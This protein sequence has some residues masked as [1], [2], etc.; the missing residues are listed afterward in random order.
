M[1]D[2]KTTEKAP[3]AEAPVPDLL[4]DALRRLVKLI[5]AVRY[6]PPGHPAL[7]AA[8]R[9]THQCFVPLLAGESLAL[10][11]RKSAFLLGESPVAPDNPVVKELAPFLFARRIQRLLLLPDLSQRDLLTFVRC[12]IRE[13]QEILN[14]GGIQ[15]VLFN[16]RVSTLGVNETDLSRLM[17]LREE[18]ET[19]GEGLPGGDADDVEDVG[20]EEEMSRAGGNV[21]I[22]AVFDPEQLAADALNLE[23]LLDRLKRESSDER[24][25][26]LLQR[27]P[28]LVRRELSEA[29][30]PLVVE[31][32]SLLC[33]NFADRHLSLSRREHTLLAIDTVSTDEILDAL[34]GWMCIRDLEEK[35]RDRIVRIL[36]FLKAKATGRLMDRL[37]AE[38]DVATRRLL[39]DVVARQGAAALPGLLEHL[40]DSRWY[41]VRNVVTILGDIRDQSAASHLTPLLSHPELRVRREVIRALTRIGGSSA[42]GILQRTIEEGDPEL[43]QQ[44]ILSLGA[45]KSATSVPILVQLVNRMDPL[46]K[47]PELKKS[48]IRALGAIGSSEA[49][50]ALARILKRAKLWR[51][52]KYA[53]LKVAAATALAAIGGDAAAAALAAA[54]RIRTP[55][56]S[57]AVAQALRQV[58]RSEGHGHGP[59]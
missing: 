28:P 11:V 51:R 12:L 37:V 34:I 10:K 17:T 19:S 25:Q 38:E 48:A 24:Y 33:R 14:E 59:V 46:V 5:K 6:Y 18:V 53:E 4:G 31:A 55:A 23:Q 49:V 26:L 32:F 47:I 20:G 50:P 21:R 56:V 39:A 8:V 44:A 3:S 27:L 57:R 58:R 30:R 2:P 35:Q 16:A 1:I 22:E 29:G 41:V 43:A 40:G 54:A 45:M 36:V 15:E 9:E 13:P 52:S 42:V 7:K